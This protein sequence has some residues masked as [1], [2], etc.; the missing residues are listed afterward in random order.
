[1]IPHFVDTGFAWLHLISDRRFSARINTTLRGR[2]SD[3]YFDHSK[4]SSFLTTTECHFITKQKSDDRA[5]YSLISENWI[6]RGNG[7][8]LELE[9]DEQRRDGK[10]RRVD[11]GRESLFQSS[12]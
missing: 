10:N 8:I 1:M 3:L 7:I 9:L 11:L 4:P 5:K 12:F 2:L 6:G